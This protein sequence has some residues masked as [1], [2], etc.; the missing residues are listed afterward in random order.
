VYNVPVQGNH[1]EEG[2]E[3]R[4]T[5]LVCFLTFLGSVSSVQAA[6]PFVGTWKPDVEKWKLS[7]GARE[8]RPS[9]TLTI[10]ATG[11]N[12]YRFTWTTVDGKPTGIPPQV[13][14]V[15]GKEHKLPDGNTY[16]GQRINERHWKVNELG[17]KGSNTYERVISPDGNTL[18]VTRKGTGPA[19]GRPLDE[20]FVYSKK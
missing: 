13:L 18:T 19:S 3:M 17:P 11:E 20:L 2:V 6:D 15:D 10:E 4:T 8:Q 14:F 1:K 5:L 16:K 7:P 9:T 12:A